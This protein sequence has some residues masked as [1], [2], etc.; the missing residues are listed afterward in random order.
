M[1]FNI[2]KGLY[3]LICGILNNIPSRDI[4]ILCIIFAS[5]NNIKND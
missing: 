1:N 4:A 3:V 2:Y 5:N